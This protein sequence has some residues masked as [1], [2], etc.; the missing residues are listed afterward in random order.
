M[1]NDEYGLMTSV[2]LQDDEATQADNFSD[3]GYS[4]LDGG[5]SYLDG[6]ID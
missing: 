3:D 5:E 6:K 1:G 2:V 4:S